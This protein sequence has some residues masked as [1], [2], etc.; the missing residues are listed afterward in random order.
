MHASL[1]QE[2]TLIALREEGRYAEALAL[3]Q[4]LYADAACAPTAEAADLFGILLEWHFLAEMHAPAR[5]AMVQ[6]RDLQI[7]RLLAGEASFWQGGDQERPSSR[8]SRFNLITTMNRTLDDERSTYDLFAGLDTR[9]PELARR[10]ASQA[11]PAV[12]AV[13][14]FAL[15]DRYR[16]APLD[17]LDTV[18]DSATRYPLFTIDGRAPRLAT[19]LMQLVR[20]VTL[21]MAVL[22]GLGRAA[23]AAPLPAALLAGLQ[24]E[25]LRLWAERELA[26]AGAIDR[27][28]GELQLQHELRRRAAAGL[29]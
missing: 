1:P 20:D 10:Y 5:A 18:N 12:V 14:D 8:L 28:V 16:R 2:N 9:Q 25:E 15:A 6:A 22:R 23:E 11:L 3:L 17:L 21:A 19:E 13:G 7:A 24:S 26:D 29:S 27:A 4:Q